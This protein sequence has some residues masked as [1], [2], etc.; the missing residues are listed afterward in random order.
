MALLEL[1][2]L[3]G[4]RLSKAP[5]NRGFCLLCVLIRMPCHR[6]RSTFE[7]GW[8]GPLSPLSPEGGEPS[9]R[10]QRPG[11]GCRFFV[12]FKSVRRGNGWHLGISPLQ[13]FA[14]IGGWR[15]SSGFSSGTPRGVNGRRRSTTE[16]DLRRPMRGLR[17][18]LVSESGA[19]EGR[20]NLRPFPTTRF[21]ALPSKTNRPPS[22]R[23]FRPSR[24]LGL[25][26]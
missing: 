15:S 20:L 18:Y 22:S 25:H 2:R 12:Y 5:G 7:L 24:R 21:W 1:K 26:A 13:F 4:T 16:A 10:V 19:V 9:S 3:L 17:R 8:P 23:L 14:M 6:R 11:P